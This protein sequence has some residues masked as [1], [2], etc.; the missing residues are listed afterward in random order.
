MSDQELLERIILNPKVMTG[1]PVIKG[2]RLTVE[3]VLN[4][5]AH[6]ATPE[7][8]LGEYEGLTPEDIRACF[9]FAV[10]S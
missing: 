5:L 10:K 8:I 1:K 2:T 9:L 6:G 7:E 3:Y 4:L